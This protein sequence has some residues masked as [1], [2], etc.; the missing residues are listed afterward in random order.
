MNYP[1]RG[2][3]ILIR[4]YYALVSQRLIL[5][6]VDTYSLPGRCPLILGECQKGKIKECKICI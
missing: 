5:K 6:G 1:I 3:S 2:H 4:H